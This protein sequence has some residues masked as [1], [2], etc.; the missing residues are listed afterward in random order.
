MRRPQIL[1]STAW[2]LQ[3]L[4]WFLPVVQ[5]LGVRLPGFQAFVVTVA[6][7]WPGNSTPQDPWYAP[8]LA[9]I[10][11]LTTLGFALG[12][13]WVVLR[14]SASVRRAAGWIA[15]AAFVFNAH[16]W[17]LGGLS[18]SELK[19]GYFF[20]WFSFAVLAFGLLDLTGQRRVGLQSSAVT[21]GSP[22]P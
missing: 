21:R 20:W 17:A 6:A 12:S 10:T 5:V 18:W 16:W 13:P 3:V 9:G 2:A 19:I 22:A 1:I 15:A 14:A 8:L 4:A 11:V 7:M